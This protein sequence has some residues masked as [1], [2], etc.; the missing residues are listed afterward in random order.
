MDRISSTDVSSVIQNSM[1]V[2][3]IKVSSNE[4]AK[5]NKVVRNHI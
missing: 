2:T 5:T 3:H 4:G 1:N